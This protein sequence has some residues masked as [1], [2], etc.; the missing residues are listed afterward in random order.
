[1]GRFSEA[2]VAF[3]YLGPAGKAYEHGR[4]AGMHERKAYRGLGTGLDIAGDEKV[5]F[6]GALFIGGIGGIGDHGTSD[7]GRGMPLPRRSS[8]QRAGGHDANYHNA[9]VMP[10]GAV[11]EMAEVIANESGRNRYAGTRVEQIVV[12]LH[13]VEASAVHHLV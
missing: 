8:A 9:H 7:G 2:D 3:L 6:G 5:E 13:N 12:G 4:Y 10:R 11:D 1:M